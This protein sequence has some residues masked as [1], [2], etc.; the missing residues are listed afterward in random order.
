MAE[1]VTTLLEK[2]Q[3]QQQ[4]HPEWTPALEDILYVN[5]GSGSDRD[6][7]YSLEQVRNLIQ[8][9]FELIHME[10]NGSKLEADGEKLTVRN[11]LIGEV[12]L[13]SGQSNMEMPLRGFDNCP[14]D[15]ALQE[16][17]ESGRYRGRIRFSTVPKVGAYS[18]RD[19]VDAPWLESCPD[20]APGFGAAAW[21]F[22]KNLNEVLDVPVGIIN[23]AWGGSRVEGWLPREIVAGYPG[24]PAASLAVSRIFEMNRPTIITPSRA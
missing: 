10:K 13:G 9:L 17:A 23:N 19:I 24:V 4:D 21:F 5:H 11:V 3:K 15:G 8:G 1:N 6:R 14:V 16:I 12:W 2:W 7:L 18:P 20:N 22:A